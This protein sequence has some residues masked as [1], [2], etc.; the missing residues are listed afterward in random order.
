MD[1]EVAVLQRTDDLKCHFVMLHLMVPIKCSSNLCPNNRTARSLAPQK[2]ERWISDWDWSGTGGQSLDNPLM[3]SYH[4]ISYHI[5]YFHSMD[6]Y[7][8]GNSHIYLRSQEVK[9]V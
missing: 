6:P 5:I 2:W 4:I 1:C 8:Y 3:L 9:S 7:G